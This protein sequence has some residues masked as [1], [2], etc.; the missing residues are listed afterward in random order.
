M[1]LNSNFSQEML[2]LA[3]STFF[4]ANRPHSPVELVQV[5]GH[6]VRAEGRA[7]EG[8]GQQ[9]P[10]LRGSYGAVNQSTHG[11]YE[12]GSMNIQLLSVI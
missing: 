3:S 8:E 7:G 10:R 12:S 6:D 4:W 11:G 1:E 2:R 9:A 5:R